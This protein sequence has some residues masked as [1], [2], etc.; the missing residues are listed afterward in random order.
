[1]LNLVLFGPPGAGK[2]TQSQHLVEHYN[3]IHISTGDLLRA[4]RKAGTPLGKKAEE[5]MTKGNLVPDEVVIGMIENKLKENKGAKGIIFDGFPRTTNQAEALDTL[6]NSHNES[7]D[8]VLSLHV[9]EEE[10]VTRLLERGKTSG[11]VDDQKEELIR[12]RVQVYR[13]ETEVVADYYKKQD[14]LHVIEGVGEI[15]EITAAIR[16]A[17]EQVKAS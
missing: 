12:N 2:G 9:D 10:L 4:E 8:A 6:L 3:L 15:S 14:K 5:Y 7:I 1:M 17:V 13:N 16:G 11:R